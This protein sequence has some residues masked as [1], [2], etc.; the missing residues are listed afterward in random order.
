MPTYTLKIALELFIEAM[1]AAD[2]Y[3]KEEALERLTLLYE[4]RFEALMLRYIERF[5]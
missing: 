5:K 4:R 2:D 3:E 1:D